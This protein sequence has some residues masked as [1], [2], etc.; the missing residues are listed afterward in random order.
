MSWDQYIEWDR[1]Y[2]M[3]HKDALE[4]WVPFTVDRIEGSWI[5]DNKGNRILDFMGGWFNINVGQRREEVIEEIKKALDRYGWAPETYVTPYKSEAAKLIIED[6]L[7][8]DNWAGRVRFV[9]S[10]SEANEEAIIIA[11]LYTNRRNILSRMAYHGWTLGAG[12]CTGIRAD[13]GI[14]ASPKTSESRDVPDLPTGG[15]YFAPSPHCY[16]CPLG[17]EYPDCKENGKLAC[18]QF[19]ENLIRMV[20]VETFA[21]MI[22]DVHIGGPSIIPPSEYIPQ[23]RKMTRDLGILWIDDEIICG[24]G[25]L[26]KW[27]G[28]QLYD[29]VTPDIMTMG[30]GISSSQLPAAG[31]VVSKEIAEFFDKYRWNHY[32]TFGAHPVSMAAIVAN[33]K[34][35]IKEKIPERA[36]KMGKYLGEKLRELEDRHKCVGLVN[37]CGLYWI[38]EIVKNKKTKEPF[39]KEDRNAA[40]AGDISSY[41]SE[42]VSRKGLEK[43]VI[44][45]GFVPNTLRIGPALNITEDE[46]NIGIEALDYALTEIDKMC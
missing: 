16:R 15:F 33:I 37:G 28:Y 42:I 40:Y 35:M 6:I 4:E 32:P 22:A 14:L 13:R 7:K 1:K 25:R 27:F 20:G 26:G 39:I 24:F 3:H 36:A 44:I 46:I 41:P 30:K 45:G 10:G 23:I 31:G 21:A 29:G 8:P 2:Y 12:S 11:R 9:V 5:I 43:G 38:V 17:C 19:T 18:V 34:L